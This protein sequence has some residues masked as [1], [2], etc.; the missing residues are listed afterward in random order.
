MATLLEPVKPHI[1]SAMAWFGNTFSKLPPIVFSIANAV[2]PAF[3][4]IGEAFKN[5]GKYATSIISIF[6]GGLGRLKV[7]CH[8]K[9]SDFLRMK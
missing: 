3:K 8:L 5:V 2:K 7:L 4:G 6:K 1:Q 9:N